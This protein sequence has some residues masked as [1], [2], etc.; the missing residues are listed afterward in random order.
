[1]AFRLALSSFH[2]WRSPENRVGSRVCACGP[3]SSLIASSFRWRSR[4]T[5]W[6]RCPQSSGWDCTISRLLRFSFS[7]VLLLSSNPSPPYLYYSEC[8]WSWAWPALRQY[9]ANPKTRPWLKYR[10]SLSKDLN[11]KFAYCQ[12]EGISSFHH[13]F[14]HLQTKLSFLWMNSAI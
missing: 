12:S 14:F 4:L 5:W 6:H 13:L 8:G 7:F 3:F 9:G 2:W 10:S 1:M 11:S